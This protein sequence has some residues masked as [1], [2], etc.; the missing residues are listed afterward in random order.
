MAVI[1]LAAALSAC[2]GAVRTGDGRELALR[3]AEFAAY[4]EG[5]F[6]LQNDVLDRLAFMLERAPGDAQAL[7]HEDRVLARCAGINAIA[8]RRRDERGTRVLA[9]ARA[10]RQVPE[11]EAAASAAALWLDAAGN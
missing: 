4:A 2:A 1:V 5:V 10:A 11:C 8:V 7:A 9:D 3:S 6:R